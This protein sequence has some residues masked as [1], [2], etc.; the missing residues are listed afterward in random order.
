MVDNKVQFG[1]VR[2]D[3]QIEIDLIS[4][5]SLKSA[6]LIGS[7]GCTAF[8][9]KTIFPNI[10][11]S[12][13][14]PNKAQINL[15]KKKIRKLKNSNLAESRRT[16]G[17]HKKHPL[18]E[19]GN[20]E[21]LFKM[22]REFIHEFVLS[23]A[24]LRTLLKTG[25]KTQ[26]QEIFKNPYWKTAFDL[27]F[28]NS[29]LV[30]MF[31]PEAIQYA[32]KDSYPKYFKTR[33]ERGLIQSDARYNYFL[34][35]IFLGHYLSGTKTLPIYLIK[36]P[37]NLRMKFN[38]CFAHEFDK[39]GDFDLVSLSN[40]LDWSSPQMVK[41][42]AAQVSSSMRKGSVLVYRQL[43]NKTDFKKTFKGFNWQTKI[44]KFILNKDRS[45]FYSKICIGIKNE[46]VKND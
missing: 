43:N 13:I 4:K 15:I 10:D 38:P 9:V 23:Q 31:G 39:Y 2:E 14:E 11:I 33:L 30:S 8:S 18:I 34:H 16:I 3:P 12:L 19:S 24:E 27:Y 20:F 45:L 1:T 17:T 28:S 35:H 21:S 7:G 25:A 22:F 32:P 5:Y 46:G 41:K 36:K 42:I 29:L 26:W 6:V 37:K 44:E 40:I